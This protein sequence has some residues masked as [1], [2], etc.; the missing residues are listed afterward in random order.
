MDNEQNLA[1]TPFD[2]IRALLESGWTPEML[3][4]E[5]QHVSLL[6]IMHY[7]NVLFTE[8]EAAEIAR[9]YDRELGE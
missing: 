6:K 8:K 2:Q 9:I 5:M 1:E 7:N 4:K 3:R